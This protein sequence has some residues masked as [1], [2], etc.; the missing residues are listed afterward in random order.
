MTVTTSET[1]LWQLHVRAA[2]GEALTDA[3]QQK[4]AEWYAVQ[5]QNER[6]TYQMMPSSDQVSTTQTQVDMLL[7][8]IATATARIKQLTDENVQLR[9]E[10]T[11]LRR[12]LTRQ[13]LLQPA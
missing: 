10:I 13:T 5:E 11:Q 8:Q 3:E 1:Y 12:Q 6:A 2:K 9:Q 4:L 7:A